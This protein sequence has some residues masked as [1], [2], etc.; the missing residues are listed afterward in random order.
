MNRL[1]ILL[2]LISTGLSAQNLQT[3]IS[4]HDPVM[5]KQGDTYYLFCTGMGISVWSSK[6]MKEWSDPIVISRGGS[7]MKQSNWYGGESECPFVVKIDNK[8]ILFRNQLYGQNNLNTQYS[9]LDPLNFGDNNDDYMIGQLPVAAPEIIKE[10][11][12]YYI[13][14]LKPGLDGMNIASCKLFYL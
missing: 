10:G 2:L 3:N 13:I 6:N 5:A 1:L 7:V 4:V 14:S 9:S 12:Q 8:Y 11:N